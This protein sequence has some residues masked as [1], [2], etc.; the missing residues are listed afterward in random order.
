MIQTQHITTTTTKRRGSIHKN[1][2]DPSILDLKKTTATQDNA[3]YNKYK[4]TQ[5]NSLNQSSRN[6]LLFTSQQFKDFLS[7]YLSEEQV[8][9][10][11]NTLFSAIEYI[12]KT[13]LGRKDIG[14]PVLCLTWYVVSSISSNLCKTILKGFPYPVALTEIQFLFTAILCTGFISLINYYERPTRNPSHASKW[15]KIFPEG[16]FPEYLDGDFQNSIQNKFLKPCKQTIQMCLPLGIFQFSGHICSHQSTSMIPVSLVHSIKALSPI[17]TVGY[18]RL[19]QNKRYDQHTYSSLT[20]IVMGVITTCFSGNGK[21][22]GTLEPEHT[23]YYMGLFFAFLSMVIFV[24]QNIFA[25]GVL[26]HKRKDQTISAP[27]NQPPQLDKITILFYCSCT[28]FVLTIPLLLSSLI[29]KG[30]SPSTATTS[31]SLVKLLFLLMLHNISHFLQAMLAFQLIGLL[32]PVNY[33]VANIVKRI[34]VICVALVWENKHS[35]LG[36]LGVALTMGGLYGYDRA[37]LQEQQE[38]KITV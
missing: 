27:T 18:Y 38:K 3:Q 37:K 28:G 1:L 13:V 2:F 11:S 4:Q 7:Y 21:K 29:F 26:T 17:V 34:V 20:I 32:S 5:R 6:G 9:T 15:L 19:A 31:Y 30:S 12:Q 35:P 24:S 36:L 22:K 14:I 33:S 25:K 16:T 23:H 8:Q 10:V